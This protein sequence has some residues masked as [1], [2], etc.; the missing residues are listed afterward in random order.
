MTKLF[1]LIDY[2][3]FYAHREAAQPRADIQQSFVFR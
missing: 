1:A 2:N 3:N